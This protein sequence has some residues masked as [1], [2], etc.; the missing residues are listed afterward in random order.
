MKKIVVSL[1]VVLFVSVMALSCNSAPK[2][3]PLTALASNTW[4][5]KSMKGEQADST[6]FARGVPY[7]EFDAGEMH[8]SGFAGCNRVMGSFGI[9]EKNGISLDKL[10]STKMACA[11]VDGETEFLSVLGTVTNFE[12][13]EKSLKFMA[14][15]SEVMTFT[16]KEGE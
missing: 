4:M 12:V 6:S 7:L 5:L 2:V 1:S 8:V 16:P 10:A 3:D 9:E 13:E 15:D 14:G 11:G